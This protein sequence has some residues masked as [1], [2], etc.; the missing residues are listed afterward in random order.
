MSICIDCNHSLNF[1]YADSKN[2]YWRCANLLCMKLIQ[3]PLNNNGMVNG[4]ECSKC[5][6]EIIIKEII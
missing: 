5:C 2:E 6:G 4:V 3:R 1:V